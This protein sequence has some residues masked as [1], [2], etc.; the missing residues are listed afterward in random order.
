MQMPDA[1]RVSSNVAMKDALSSENSANSNGQFSTKKLQQSEHF[2]TIFKELADADKSNKSNGSVIDTA[3]DRPIDQLEKPAPV[4]EKASPN[5]DELE[6]SKSPED[7]HLDEAGG[8]LR[9]AG[10]ET[11]IAADV[12]ENAI[13]S[14]IPANQPH[15][16]YFQ[17]Q[18]G[19][20]VLQR[21]TQVLNPIQ[22]NAAGPPFPVSD[23]Q[24]E[25]IAQAG[26]ASLAKPNHDIQSMRALDE[27]P[28]NRQLHFA[29]KSA[30]V[31]DS[32]SERPRFL[33]D[34]AVQENGF[35]INSGTLDDPA[36]LRREGFKSG[37][38]APSQKIKIPD[39]VTAM[40]LKPEAR[41]DTRDYK[42]LG[43]EGLGE[44]LNGSNPTEMKSSL[45]PSKG[46]SQKAD[47]ISG[48]PSILA[49]HGVK[50]G[51]KTTNQPALQAGASGPPI[52]SRL[53]EPDVLQTSTMNQMGDE[54]SPR[55]STPV[56]N[57]PADVER[58]QADPSAPKAL[59]SVS[60][61]TDPRLAQ[62][63][64][65]PKTRHE[66]TEVKAPLLPNRSDHTEKADFVGHAKAFS[67]APELSKS[68]ERKEFRASAQEGAQGATPSLQIRPQR[69]RPNTV[70]TMQS[71][72]AGQS[73]DEGINI[74]QRM[75]LRD[76][77]PDQ[78]LSPVQITEQSR[79]TSAS[80][81]F[82]AIRAG[83]PHHIPKQ[84]AEVIHT[85]GSKSVEVALSPEELGRVRLSI[86][87]AE[88]GLLVNIQAE[89]PETLEML[90]RNIEQLDKE[91]Q[92]LGYAEPGFSFS[93]EGGEPDKGHDNAI[94]RAPTIE[95]HAS[96][97]L[98]T[99][100]ADRNLDP[101]TQSGVDI[102]L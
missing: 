12:Q 101:K 21:P 97:S 7:D 53:S 60:A 65:P 41:P 69:A 9:K 6:R 102:R 92:L 77:S 57:P 45:V 4:N 31:T 86:T 73:F 36:S 76:D 33:D 58:S 47:P 16:R 85:S 10:D 23:T 11:K 19:A 56:N 75:G 99:S 29:S 24:S 50:Q 34:L 28:L 64:Q 17:S 89:R 1:I 13:G 25:L 54:I 46:P 67:P 98:S 63:G 79:G 18:S 44:R 78:E 8:A 15:P 42:E 83:V 14:N 88:S 84:L 80:P 5:G 40:P 61:L 27:A 94:T 68:L 66:L 82:T 96:V 52:V 90:R 100:T 93:S 39:G 48:S 35:K 37:L 91:L 51:S 71:A 22:G 87:Q 49:Q 70:P 74:N 3:A 26:Q 81:Q 2:S 62:T 30:A 32:N 95:E 43:R 72:R 59:D 38:G 55:L 20:A